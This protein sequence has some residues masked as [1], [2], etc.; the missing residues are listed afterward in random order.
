MRPR[1]TAHA[2]EQAAAKGF[3]PRDVWLAHTDPD[4]AYPSKEPNRV[5][6]IRGGIVV[7]IDPRDNTA[8]TVHA[9]IIET[10][11]REDQLR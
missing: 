4:V 11:L 8:I 7:V 5:R 10:P 9:N 3:S 1:I 2:K 6:H